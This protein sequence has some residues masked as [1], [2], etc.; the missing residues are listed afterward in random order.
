[1][2]G[3]QLTQD[4]ALLKLRRPAKLNDH[5]KIV[6]YDTEDQFP[7]GSACEVGGWGQ[8]A[9]GKLTLLYCE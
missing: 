6:D 1:M 2:A 7:P 5:V 3:S 8:I 4:I 9:S